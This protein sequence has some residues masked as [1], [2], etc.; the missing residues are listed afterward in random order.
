VSEGLLISATQP[1]A[2]DAPQPEESTSSSQ[3][4]DLIP[5]ILDVFS[6]AFFSLPFS[7]VTYM[8]G[9]WW[10]RFLAEE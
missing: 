10:N 8:L 3:T 2:Q 1:E 9:C 5:E 7:T 6:S 4:V